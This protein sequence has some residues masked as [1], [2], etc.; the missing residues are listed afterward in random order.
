[1]NCRKLTFSR[2]LLQELYHFTLNTYFSTLY[3]NRKNLRFTMHDRK[4]SLYIR[5]YYMWAILAGD[6]DGGPDIKETWCWKSASWYQNSTYHQ[7][8]SHHPPVSIFLYLSLIILS[9][10][11]FYISPTGSV[12]L[13]PSVYL[14]NTWYV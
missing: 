1:M 12:F 6:P 9:N 13:S 14:N 2:L 4:C 8:M 11:S 3:S 7:Q 5:A 10:S